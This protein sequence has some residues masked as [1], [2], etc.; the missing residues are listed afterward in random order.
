MRTEVGGVLLVFAMAATAAHGAVL[1]ARKRADGT[2]SSGVAIREAC[3]RSESTL[4]P[5]ALGLQG[6]KG[7]PGM[8]GPPGPAGPSTLSCETVQLFNNGS[9]PSGADGNAV[10]AARGSFCVVAFTD[11]GYDTHL[12]C[13]V[14][15]GGCPFGFQSSNA[16]VCCH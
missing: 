1:C 8:A 16:V 2:Y 5:S 11:S 3:K 7:D 13:S 15:F 12:D 10:C 4:D 14:S 9:C 6:P